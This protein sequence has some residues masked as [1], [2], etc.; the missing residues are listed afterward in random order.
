MTNGRR[1]QPARGIHAIQGQLRGPIQDMSLLAPVDE[2]TAVENR[3]TW[4]IFKRGVHQVII[5]VHPADGGV[6]IKAWQNR[7]TKCSGHGL[8]LSTKK[9]VRR[10]QNN[11]KRSHSQEV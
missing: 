7:V 11:R 4:K 2:V 5:L 10:N 1:I 8:R 6:R 9:V 3:Q